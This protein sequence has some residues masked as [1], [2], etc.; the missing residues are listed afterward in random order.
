MYVHLPYHS[1]THPLDPFTLYP[2]P[3]THN[4]VHPQHLAPNLKSKIP[5][6]QVKLVVHQCRNNIR[7]PYSKEMHL[8]NKA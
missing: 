1:P 2:K 4:T 3:Y 5:Q 8:Q 6:I 7:I